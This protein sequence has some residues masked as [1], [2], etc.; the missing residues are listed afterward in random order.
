MEIYTNYKKLNKWLVSSSE[1]F[2]RKKDTQWYV[3]C[4]PH[5]GQVGG[6]YVRTSTFTLR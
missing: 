5:V 1:T 3:E 6:K 2:L 4:P